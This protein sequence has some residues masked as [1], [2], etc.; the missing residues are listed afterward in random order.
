MNDSADRRVSELSP[1][2]WLDNYGDHLYRYAMLHLNNA[3]LAEDLVQDTLV[4]AL[5]G[6][7]RYEGRASE[8]TWLTGILRYKILDILRAQSR[9]TVAE[10]IEDVADRAVAEIDTLFDARGGWLTPPQDW[11]Q[12][13]QR[14]NDRQFLSALAHCMQNLKPT[15]QT[16]F[17]LKEVNGQSN[18]EISSELGVT[19]SNCGV[20]LYRARMSLRRCL[21]VRW[22]DDPRQS[23]GDGATK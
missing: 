10:D 19:P 18:G 23:P 5:E 8:K 1:D 12:P 16:A 2:R 7:E 20:L 15:M 3:A 13:E 22:V 21:D 9:E 17:L 11:G 6:I 14:L 4:A